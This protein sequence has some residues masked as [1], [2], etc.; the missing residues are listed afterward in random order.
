MFANSGASATNAPNSNFLKPP[1]SNA[2]SN[3]SASRPLFG[4]IGPN[5]GLQ[6]GFS[7]DP[8]SQ[9]TDFS[10]AGST[11]Q[12]R[13]LFNVPATMT[14]P[15][16]QTA[17][18]TSAF[19]LVQSINQNTNQASATPFM[20]STQTQA[21]QAQ[22]G[23]TAQEQSQTIAPGSLAAFFDDLLQRGRKGH[24]ESSDDNGLQKLP[25]LQLGLSDISRRVRELGGGPRRGTADAGRSADSKA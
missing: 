24:M 13:S 14:Q 5:R 9:P 21:A 15:I 19:P 16:N 17:N 11:A 6:S 18:Q 22:P 25:S 12:T 2:P 20:Q 10:L 7:T 3:P 23:P 1:A 8:T 4:E